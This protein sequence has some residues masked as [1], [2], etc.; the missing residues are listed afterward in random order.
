MIINIINSIIIIIKLLLSL[1]FT[2]LFVIGSSKKQ[3]ENS[4]PTSDSTSE[5]D[6]CIAVVGKDSF[7]SKKMLGCYHSRCF[8]H[9]KCLVKDKD[10]PVAYA[11]NL[12]STCMEYLGHCHSSLK[13]C[14][15][16]FKIF[17]HMKKRFGL[18]FG[19][20]CQPLKDWFFENYKKLQDSNIENTTVSYED[21]KSREEKSE[22][23]P[24]DKL[25]I[26]GEELASKDET[27]SKEEGSSEGTT[28]EQKLP[29][30][31]TSAKDLHALDPNGKSD[32]SD[33]S[34]KTS[35]V[36]SDKEKDAIFATIK[37]PDLRFLLER[38][39]GSGKSDVVKES[40]EPSDKFC[41]LLQKYSEIKR[42]QKKV[43]CHSYAINLEDGD[44]FITEICQSL[45]STLNGIIPSPTF[46]QGIHAQ[47]CCQNEES[48]RVMMFLQ[49]NQFE[50]S[51]VSF[52]MGNMKGYC[53]GRLLHKLNFA[54][55][56]TK[57]YFNFYCAFRATVST[58]RK[59]K[60]DKTL[61]PDVK[62]F[63]STLA[64]S[65][66]S[67]TKEMIIP[68]KNCIQLALHCK[69]KLRSSG[70]KAESEN[71]LIDKLVKRNI[72]SEN[73][74]DDDALIEVGP[75]CDQLSELVSKECEKGDIEVLDALLC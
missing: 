56:L 59:Y 49:R 6:S 72:F 5:D 18:S 37:N 43:D 61:E 29:E 7:C 71:S 63:H 60:V 35:S 52:L 67:L 57:S 17:K 27:S 3:L 45:E 26:E 28:S 62:E 12:C 21:F 69:Q 20:Q 51:D 36:L 19:W 2:F 13:C 14:E 73:I 22:K 53:S 66:D 1:F 70:F 48:L 8:S 47:F 16:I 54:M 44:P 9:A 24:D 33:A 46:V 65:L 25:G 39:R 40:V 23:D 32:A 41:V 34:A 75:N 68:L 4:S 38:M 58:I 11:P 10:N 42:D 64:E 30:K 50:L 55:S 15:R 31:E 74:F